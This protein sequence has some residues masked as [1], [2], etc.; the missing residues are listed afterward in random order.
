LDYKKRLKKILKIKDLMTFIEISKSDINKINAK[1]K[2]EF[3]EI[4]GYQRKIRADKSVSGYKKK[5]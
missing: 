5:Y 2:K 4:I 3:P 1:I